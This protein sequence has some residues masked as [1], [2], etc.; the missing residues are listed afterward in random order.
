MRTKTNSPWLLILTMIFGVSVA[1][2]QMPQSNH[3]II[4]MEENHSYENVFN[5]TSM[6]W[7]TSMAK[8]YASAE[9]SYANAHYSLPNYMWLTAGRAVTFHDNTTAKF[10][11]DNIVR[12][13][14]VG[15]K[16]WKEYAEGLPYIGY[17]GYNTGYYVERH[18]PF[19]YFTDVAYSSEKS[20]IVPFTHFAKDINGQRLP[21][22]AFV[23]PNLMHDA[24]NGTLAEADQ[25]LK[26]YI[27]PV[28]KSPAFQ[29]G[30]DGVLIITFDE[31]HDSDCRPNPSC[32]TLPGNVG[33]G[34]VATVMIGPKVKRGY[35]SS[36]RYMEQNVL[37]TALDLLGIA[38]GPGASAS[39]RPMADMFR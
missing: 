18:N 32:G 31:S 2:G 23:T 29:P 33:G 19:A 12:Y 34:R 26:N 37:R 9:Y 16:T 35:R 14:L 11:V 15:G 6:P 1:Y 38:G 24:H 30:G 39:A 13:L 20:N 17:T 4:V 5:G 36:A 3:V 21:N 25:W 22:F 10:N 7:L 27:A 28:L 8:Q